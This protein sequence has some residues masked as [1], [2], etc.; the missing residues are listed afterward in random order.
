[1]SKTTFAESELYPIKIKKFDRFSKKNFAE[2]KLSPRLISLSLRL[3]PHQSSL[4]RTPVRPSNVYL[5]SY[6]PGLE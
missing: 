1:M 5:I 6:Q 2:C 4:Q 3:K